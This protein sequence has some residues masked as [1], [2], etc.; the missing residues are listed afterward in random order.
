MPRC[1]CDESVA[2]HIMAAKA[3]LRVC[4]T[5]MCTAVARSHHTHHLPHS[6]CDAP[7]ALRV[8]CCLLVLPLTPCGLCQH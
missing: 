4:I 7:G 3:A 5:S 1:E 8:C 6:L 2:S